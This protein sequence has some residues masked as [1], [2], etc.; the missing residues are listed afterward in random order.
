MP[1]LAES[2]DWIALEKPAG[3][4]VRAHPWDAIPDMD[5]ALNT[6]LQSEKPELLRRS[7]EIF[8]SV[9]YL[10]P[11]IAGIAVFAKTRGATA[12]LRNRFGSGECR[13]RFQ[14]VAAD[15]GPG[16]P[17]EL[18]ADAPLLPHNVKPKM[19]PSTAKGKKAFTDFKRVAESPKGWV[20]WEA[21]VDFFRPHQIRAHAAVM[22]IPILG[23]DLY[24]GP[25]A[26]AQ[27]DLQPRK[28]RAGVHLPVFHGVAL[29]LGEVQLIPGDTENVIHCEPPKHLRLLYRRMGL[30]GEA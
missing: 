25:K 1:V 5:A 2:V 17:T 12:D 23:D 27:R 18:R 4:G 30:A 20:L 7:A 21:T 15:Q 8:A 13:F 29:H 16:K 28:Q 10:D 22:E 6:Q 11:V 9:Y 3:V 26:P 14:F 19:I 24:G